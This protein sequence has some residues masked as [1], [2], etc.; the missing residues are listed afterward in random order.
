MCNTYF[1]I[2]PMQRKLDVFDMFMYKICGCK[3][4]YLGLLTNIGLGNVESKCLGWI[5]SCILKEAL[6]DAINQLVVRQEEFEVGWCCRM[7]LTKLHTAFL[8]DVKEMGED[9]SWRIWRRRSWNNFV[10]IGVG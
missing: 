4:T 8:L 10:K 7:I 2:V 9:K 3:L 1:G 6:W 5:F